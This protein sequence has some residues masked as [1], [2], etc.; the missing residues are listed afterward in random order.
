[1][2]FGAKQKTFLIQSDICKQSHESF[3]CG[4]GVE[5]FEDYKRVPAIK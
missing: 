2:A 1:V 3:G 5:N 4:Y